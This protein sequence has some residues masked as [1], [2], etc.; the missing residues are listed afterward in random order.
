MHRQNAVSSNVSTSSLQV[1]KDHFR[2]NVAIPFLENITGALQARYLLY[3]IVCIMPTCIQ[4]YFRFEDG[5]SNIVKGTL[6]LPSVV[7]TTPPQQWNEAIKP[8]FEKYGDEMPSPNT[9]DSELVLWKQMWYEKW[10]EKQ[11]VLEEQ[12]YKATGERWK[13]SASELKRL[14]TNGVP[15]SVTSAIVNTNKDMFPNVHYILTLLAVIPV[16]SCEAER[17]I[18]SLRHR[19]SYLRSTME[20]DRLT[21]LALMY[22]HS[23]IHVNMDEIV[24]DFAIMH[25][26]RMRFTNI[27]EDQDQN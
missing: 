16:T 3:R 21:G 20:Q 18:S 26:R 7:I 23:H 5:Q 13:L 14:K 15:N 4:I 10:D 8:F 27:L 12:N 6:I 24:D 22:I 25:P 1:A 19:K 17:C 9:L 2:V 11:K